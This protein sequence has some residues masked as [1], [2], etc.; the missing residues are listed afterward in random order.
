MY[1]VYI[2]VYMKTLYELLFNVTKNNCT[3]ENNLKKNPSM[4]VSN[5]LSIKKKVSRFFSER[6]SLARPCPSTFLF[7][8]FSFSSRKVSLRNDSSLGPACWQWQHRGCW[9]Q[10]RCLRR[11]GRRRASFQSEIKKKTR[12]VIFFEWILVMIIMGKYGLETNEGGK[13]R[14][15]IKEWNLPWQPFHWLEFM[16]MTISKLK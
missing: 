8:S 10:G 14:T 16:M 3:Y 5:I 6:Y 12:G 15:Q 1:K 9:R 11:E 13:F 7:L 4:K 2:Q